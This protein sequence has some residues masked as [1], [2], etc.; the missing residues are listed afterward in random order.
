ML[1]YVYL[2]ILLNRSGVRRRTDGIRAVMY[3]DQPTV[4]SGVCVAHEYPQPR[5]GETQ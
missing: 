2:Q 1:V 4:V 5:L 3:Q